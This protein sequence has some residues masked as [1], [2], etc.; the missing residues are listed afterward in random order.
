[1]RKGIVALVAFSLGAALFG[2]GRLALLPHWV[3]EGKKVREIMARD[4]EEV[5]AKG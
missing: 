1:M 2:R 4:K 5:E 3:R